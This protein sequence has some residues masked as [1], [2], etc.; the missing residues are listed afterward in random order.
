MIKKSTKA[1]KNR[2]FIMTETHTA[3]FRGNPL[4][5]AKT[6]TKTTLKIQLND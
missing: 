1:T 5:K 3:N 2:L 6:T 4:R